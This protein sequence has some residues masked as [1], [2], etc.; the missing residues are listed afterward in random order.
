MK[1]GGVI[2]RQKLCQ[3]MIKHLMKSSCISS[4]VQVKKVEN[5]DLFVFI[6][7]T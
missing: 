3:E 4:S 1:F 6:R 5:P 2:L 7:F